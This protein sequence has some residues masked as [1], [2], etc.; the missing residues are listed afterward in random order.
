MQ[1]LHYVRCCIQCI[2][3]S[4]NMENSGSDL[5]QQMCLKQNDTVPCWIC[6][7][8]DDTLTMFLGTF[9]CFAQIALPLFV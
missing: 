1:V 2:N 9:A 7:D 6:L 4:Q 5:P 8:C 3:M